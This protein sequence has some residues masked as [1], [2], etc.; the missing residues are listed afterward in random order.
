[1]SVP[2]D[3]VH[4]LRQWVLKAEED[5]RA[6]TLLAALVTREGDDA[7]LVAVCF[8]AQQCVEKYIKALLTQSGIGVRKTHNLVALW[9][10]LPA[11]QSAAFKDEDLAI[12][13]RYAVQ[14][15]YPEDYEPVTAEEAATMVQLMTE[16][17]A[18]ARALLPPA[19]FE[20]PTQ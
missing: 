15:R 16:L 8:H 18:V 2:P 14:Q 6:A 11:A 13:T 5:F 9:R 19:S 20:K 7:P 12:L 10:A 1:M 17:R 4:S 3:L